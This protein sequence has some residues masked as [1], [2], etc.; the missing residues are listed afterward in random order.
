LIYKLRKEK[1][2][3]MAFVTVAL[4][5]VYTFGTRY[6]YQIYLN[7]NGLDLVAQNNAE[8][9]EEY[10]MTYNQNDGD[11]LYLPEGVKKDY[12]LTRGEVILREDGSE[13]NSFHRDGTAIIINL[14]GK[15][16]ENLELPLYNYKGYKAYDLDTGEEIEVFPS[17]N[18]LVSIH[19]EKGH[20]NVE[21]KY[22]GTTIQTIGDY[23]SMIS[24]VGLAVI[25]GKAKRK[26]GR[27]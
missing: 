26:E 1:L 25:I 24:L 7:I 8:A 2:G 5:G 6:A 12:Y 13:L 14:D 9:L 16:E 19:V 27:S 3:R 22:Y 15:N 10:D 11:N 20:R 21:V 4:I 17:D 23:I 18:K